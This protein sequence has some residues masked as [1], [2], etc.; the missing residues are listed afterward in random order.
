MGLKVKVCGLKDP[1]NVKLISECGA[2]FLGFIFFRN[3]KRFVGSSPDKM[4]FSGI[5]E[6]IKK[7]GVFVD[8]EPARIL[9]WIE[10]AG[11][12]AIQLHG[13]ES[14]NCCKSLKDTG[15]QVIKAFGVGKGFDPGITDGYS[16]VCDFFLFDTKQAEYGGSGNKFDWNILNGYPFKKPFFIS[17]G[18]GPGD[19]D[20]SAIVSNEQFFGIDI[21]SRFEVSPGI[22]DAIAVKKFINDIKTNNI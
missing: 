17:G 21:N 14:V 2:D 19:K 8:E 11:L 6:F 5:S 12:D 20:I 4:L 15:L 13:N 22:K 18:I 1:L 9:E 16:A 10:Y 7:T 3:S